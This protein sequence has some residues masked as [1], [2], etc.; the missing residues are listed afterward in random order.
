VEY[1]MVVTVFNAWGQEIQETYLSGYS[2][3]IDL[4][5]LPAG[6]YFVSGAG[7][8]LTLTGKVF[9]KM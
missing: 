6:I 9:V 4:T 3:E 5:G 8:N 1:E 2:G 7:Q